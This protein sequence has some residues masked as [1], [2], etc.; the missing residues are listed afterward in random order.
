MHSAKV[1]TSAPLIRPPKPSSSSTGVVE[2]TAD[3]P[4]VGLA[5][6]QGV[7][8]VLQLDPK[9]AG[10]VQKQLLKTLAKLRPEVARVKGLALRPSYSNRTLGPLQSLVKQTNGM[11]ERILNA[12]AV[13]PPLYWS[14]LSEYQALQGKSAVQLPSLSHPG[15][16]PS[17]VALPPSAVQ[18]IGAARAALE[19]GTAFRIRHRDLVMG[20]VGA[21]AN[22][23]SEKLVAQWVKNPA[24]HINVS[25]NRWFVELVLNGLDASLETQVGKFGLGFLST[26]GFLSHEATEGAKVQII[27]RTSELCY[28]IG[29]EGDPL[30][31][32]VTFAGV[33]S[34]RQRAAGTAVFIR[35]N[36]GQFGPDLLQRLGSELT[37]LEFHPDARIDLCLEGETASRRAVGK[38]GQAHV[39]VSLQRDFICVE[40][41]GHGIAPEIATT[42]LLTPSVSSRPPLSKKKEIPPTVPPPRLVKSKL[43]AQASE[44]VITVAGVKVVALPMKPPIQGPKDTTLSLLLEFPAWTSHTLARNEVVFTDDGKSPEE[45][46]LH[47]LI[48]EQIERFF[49]AKN[50]RGKESR[51]LS[52]L[53]QGLRLYEATT[54]NHRVA[55]T[56]TF[57]KRLV[58]GVVS[59]LYEEARLVPVPPE[60]SGLL[61]DILRQTHGELEAV[62]LDSHLT[63]GSYRKA[64]AR[65][66]L[67]AESAHL[68]EKDPQK[69]ELV[70]RAGAQGLVKGMSVVFVPDQVLA[71]HLGSVQPVRGGLRNVLFVPRSQLVAVANLELEAAARRLAKNIVY[72]TPRLDLEVSARS[73]TQVE[74]KEPD[75]LLQRLVFSS[76][77]PTEKQGCTIFHPGSMADPH[78]LFERVK[79][80]VLAN[81]WKA[82]LKNEQAN[83]TQSAWLRQSFSWTFGRTNSPLTLS[84]TRPQRTDDNGYNGWWVNP[85]D[86]ERIYYLGKPNDPYT[87]A[88]MARMLVMEALSSLGIARDEEQAK[89]HRLVTRGEALLPLGEH[90]TVEDLACLYVLGVQPDFRVDRLQ[91]V[92]LPPAK[93]PLEDHPKVR[94]LKAVGR[95][96]IFSGLGTATEGAPEDMAK[97]FGGFRE[98]TKRLEDVR[99]AVFHGR[100]L[101]GPQRAMEVARPVV[102]LALVFAAMEADP[103][104]PLPKR[105]RI[106]ELHETLMRLYDRYL[107]VD[108]DA[109]QA[110][111]GA[112]S[113]LQVSVQSSMN[114][115]G[116]ILRPLSALTQA[117]SVDQLFHFTNL[118]VED[119][120][121]VLK[122]DND[123]L[124]K[125]SFHVRSLLDPA[126][127]LARMINLTGQDVPVEALSR[128]VEGSRSA[129]ELMVAL[130]LLDQFWGDQGCREMQ[131]KTAK[132]IERE[133]EEWEQDGLRQIRERD[134]R[135]QEVRPKV[136]PRFG[137]DEFATSCEVFLREFLQKRMDPMDLERRYQAARTSKVEFT[138]RDRKDD[139][140]YQE[141]VGYLKVALDAGPGLRL[142]HEK[143]LSVIER[144]EAK[145]TTIEAL[146]AAHVGAPELREALA[147]GDLTAAMQC[148]QRYPNRLDLRKL[149]EATEFASERSGVQRTVIELVQ[150]SLDATIDFSKKS[151]SGDPSVAASL[152]ARRSAGVSVVEE[153]PKVELDF[154]L[155][156]A[157]EVSQLIIEVRDRAGIPNLEVLMTDLLLPDFSRKSGADSIGQLGNGFFQIYPEA[158]EVTVTTRLVSDPSKVYQLGLVPMRDENGHIESISVSLRELGETAD[159]Q[160]FGTKVEVTMRPEPKQTVLLRGIAARYFCHEQ[161]SSVTR[162]AN[163]QVV[164]IEVLE[165]DGTNRRR[166]NPEGKLNQLEVYGAA[167]AH[168][169]QIRA[170]RLDPNTP[171][172]VSLKGYKFADLLPFLTKAALLPPNMI[173]ELQYG[174][175][176]DLSDLGEPVQSRTSVVLTDAEKNFIREGLANFCYERGLES[177]KGLEYTFLHFAS[178]STDFYNRRII[179]REDFNERLSAQTLARTAVL[180]TDFFTHFAARRLAKLRLSSFAHFIE[181]GYQTL[182]PTIATIERDAA[183][184]WESELTGKIE[185]VKS[186]RSPKD[187]YLKVLME[188]SAANIDLRDQ[189]QQAASQWVE[190]LREPTTLQSF[191]KQGAM[192]TAQEIEAIQQ[193][194]DRVVGPWFL[195]AVN[196][197][198]LSV[199]SPQEI[200]PSDRLYQLGNA[201]NPP[202]AL[203][204]PTSTRVESLVK[205]VSQPGEITTLTLEF[206]DPEKHAALK[207]T[208]TSALA[209][210]ASLQLR[211]SDQNRQRSVAV[212][213]YLAQRW[214]A[215]VAGGR[216]W[217][218]VVHAPMSGLASI[219]LD[220]VEGGMLFDNPL[221]RRLALSLPGESGVL[222]H[223]VQHLRDEDPNSDAHGARKGFDGSVMPFEAAASSFAVAA[224]ERGLVDQFEEKIQAMLVESGLDAAWLR[225][226]VSLY[227]EL[228][229]GGAGNQL[230]DALNIS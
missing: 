189:V 96:D 64:E 33:P 3:S 98:L 150:N 133:H 85:E 99:F 151:K 144:K 22:E 63:R 128:I 193:L 83:P 121:R 184:N 54:G 195:N 162:D 67:L 68:A 177:S 147:Q 92:P 80:E 107:H 191:T 32:E 111:Y 172:A 180:E 213:L 45:Q 208:I 49:Q 65:F 221:F 160:F 76:A 40:D 59:R 113:G 105:I 25:P 219:L 38:A 148:I 108:D 125:G 166:L 90:T 110:I 20:A 42:A 53:A 202:T 70:R 66:R 101:T 196:T 37:C 122:H 146:I 102:Q 86:S 210:Y 170:I 152:E 97:G 51:V 139:A 39:S 136:L 73:S 9:L 132:R 182:V 220:V 135:S 57:S 169:G 149:I 11:V 186:A 218:S 164:G 227:L 31:A 161:F 117:L 171:S 222:N 95:G 52:A 30:D 118:L 26:L 35:P 215:W 61:A 75:S 115:P 163:G 6:A 112:S 140:L 224:R 1:M 16:Q 197:K 89:E 217:L 188:L 212:G 17:Q 141:W 175:V 47:Q 58:E 19:G 50:T 72:A 44:F 18:N 100:R 60:T 41:F 155:Y 181:H 137:C 104:L 174:W 204:A 79:P 5:P 74:N 14:V 203:S 158:E 114:K 124:R 10:K 43:D 225:E 62:P 173:E 190:N 56:R 154:R 82:F 179:P 55:S 127:P 168:G 7:P 198:T 153:A 134:G 216:I 228:E 192:L 2:K 211:L 13:L 129:E 103:G 15:Y 120:T 226:A 88:D 69:A 126:S 145:T 36:E 8:T 81:F 27:T 12:G 178:A 23:F 157:G 77:D 230:A 206:P 119:A 106:A 176:I 48:D 87:P 183:R 28:Q 71:K 187:A 21:A 199:P 223:E 131:P 142:V 93:Y 229:N 24:K 185:R 94:R 109:V 116:W 91:A 200:E 209:E 165:I 207:S 130:D 84:P 156:D 123:A 205:K 159:R 34:D 194:I 167:N 201:A 29:L 78:G 214:V 138:W 143:P 46:Y 4:S